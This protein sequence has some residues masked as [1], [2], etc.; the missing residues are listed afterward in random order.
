MAYLSRAPFIWKGTFPARQSQELQSLEEG[1]ADLKAEHRRSRLDICFELLEIIRDEGEIK[2]TQ[3][4][5]K[6]NLSWRTLDE[7]LSFL[8]ERG[9]VL[10]S[11]VGA[12]KMLSL[13][14]KG[15]TCLDDLKGAWSILM[16]A[17]PTPLPTA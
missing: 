2:P 15:S 6:A 11:R 17:Q 13:T 3:L 12:R 8:S 16:P 1:S 4:M 14:E 5:Y 10:T 9:L 7:L